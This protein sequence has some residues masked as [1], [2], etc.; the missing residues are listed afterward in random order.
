MLS[1]FYLN[2]NFLFVTC[3]NFS[4]C[5]MLKEENVQLTHKIN[6]LETSPTTAHQ[7][8]VNDLE[9]TVLTLRGMSFI[10]NSQ[11]L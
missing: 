10:S 1:R 8:K 9:Q 5:E 7:H 2:S 3:M 6:S 4:Y 11:K